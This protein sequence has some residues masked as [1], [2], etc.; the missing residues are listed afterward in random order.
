MA[1]GQVGVAHGELHV[2][3]AQEFLDRSE[4]YPLHHQMG[5]KGVPQI[6]EAEVNDPDLVA[7][8]LE[9]IP[10]IIEP[11]SVLRGGKSFMNWKPCP[12]QG[13]R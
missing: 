7:G 4:P 5:G 10:D 1:G 2:A 9:G 13:A 12:S 8:G 6:M 11:F 3:V